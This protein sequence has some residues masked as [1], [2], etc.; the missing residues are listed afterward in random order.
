MKSRLNV[1]PKERRFVVPLLFVAIVFAS[2]NPLYGENFTSLSPLTVA[3]S[4]ADGLIASPEPDWPQWRG[5]RRDGISDEKGLLSS[6]PDGGSESIGKQ[7]GQ[8]TSLKTS[9]PGRRF[10]PTAGSIASTRKAPWAC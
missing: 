1:M 6:W 9:Q 7:A 4:P 2:D 10:T 5:P 3:S 8:G